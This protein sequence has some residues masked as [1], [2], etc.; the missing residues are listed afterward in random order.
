MYDC[1]YYKYKPNSLNLQRLV[2][3][4]GLNSVP[5]KRLAACIIMDHRR[6]KF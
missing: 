1:P 2:A 5:Y 3:I 6:E 4:H